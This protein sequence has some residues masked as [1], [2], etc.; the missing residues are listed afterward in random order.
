MALTKII[1]LDEIARPVYSIKR[2]NDIIYHLLK[3]YIQENGQLQNIVVYLNDSGKYEVIKGRMIYK[4]LDEL[5]IGFAIVHDLGKLTE[6]DAKIHYL[7]L[8]LLR[9]EIDTV[10]LAYLVRDLFTTFDKMHLS[11]I[12][13]LSV[14]E[15][16]ALEKIFDFDWEQYKTEDEKQ[17][18]G[19]F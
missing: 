4:V 10:E 15:F 5:G 12:L 16:E 7:K 9:N 11:K 19:L 17:Q 1:T 14:D 3:Q 13:P 18:L 2:N 8:S 6:K